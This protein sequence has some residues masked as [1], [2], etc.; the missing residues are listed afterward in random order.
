MD[1]PSWKGLLQEAADIYVRLAEHPDD[2]WIRQERDTFLSR[3]E[4]EQRAYRHIAK[5]WRASRPRKR[6]SRVAPLI[7]L[8]GL[9]FSA[10]YSWEQFH[11][12]V[13]AD[14]RTIHETAQKSLQ[15][16]DRV[17]MDAAT[18]LI[19]HTDAK[20][21]SFTLLGGAAFF[22]VVRDARPFVVTLRDVEI[23]AI[24]TAFETAFLEDQISV[25]VQE[26]VV[27]VQTSSLQRELSAGEQIIVAPDG[28]IQLKAVREEEIA[29]WRDDR[30]VADGMALEEVAAIVSRRIPGA[31]WVTNEGLASVTVSGRFDLQRPLSALRNAAAAAGGRVISAA[32]M[33]TLVISNAEN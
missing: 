20:K 29:T 15:S 30:L 33:L 26:G 7:L 1:Q 22:T 8:I 32:P 21:R 24:G 12:H 19:E 16:G 5:V 28:K 13:I 3:G 31:V 10:Y 11:L 9:I 18:A 17:D 6:R 2:D 4:A 27:S 23:R 25:A 14:L